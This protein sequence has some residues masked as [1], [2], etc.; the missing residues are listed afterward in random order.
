M[1]LPTP[2]HLPPPPSSEQSSEINATLQPQLA[3]PPLEKSPSCPTTPL[4]ELNRRCSPLPLHLTG[5]DVTA[6]DPIMTSDPHEPVT[7]VNYLINVNVPPLI[8]AMM[9]ILLFCWW[10]FTGNSTS[11]PGCVVK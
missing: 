9:F 6:Q 2:S 7:V 3:P 5:E 8:K 11:D 4:A 1:T 10:K